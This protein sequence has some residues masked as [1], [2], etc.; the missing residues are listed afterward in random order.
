M[1]GDG[2]GGGG[3]GDRGEIPD[4]QRPKQG[5]SQVEVFERLSQN[6]QQHPKHQ[7]VSVGRGVGVWGW[8]WGGGG[9]GG[10]QFPNQQF[11]TQGTVKLKLFQRPS[12]K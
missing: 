12:Q 10:R 7:K 6:E 4:Q 2:G 9:G 3:G 1:R 8:G 11:L 5:M